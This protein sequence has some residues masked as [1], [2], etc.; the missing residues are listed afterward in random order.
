VE[1]RSVKDLVFGDA[2]EEI[3]VLR[4]ELWTA[5]QGE[6][7]SRKAIDDLSVT[8]SDI[9]MEAKQV[10]LWLSEEHDRC[11][12]EAEESAVTWG[13][14]ERVLLDRVRASEEVN[15][16]RQENTKLVELHRV[17]RE[18]VA[19]GHP[20]AGRCRGQHCQADKSDRPRRGG[21]P[22]PA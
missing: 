18:P 6:E 15:R 8:L 11:R 22:R 1:Q 10:K 19:V 2:D 5:I 12:L 4:H 17:I 3:R 7:R 14:K 13:D 9:T 16:A 20:Q 21:V